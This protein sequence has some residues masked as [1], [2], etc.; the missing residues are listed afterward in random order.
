[1]NVVVQIY[2]L[3]DATFL[4]KNT[5]LDFIIIPIRNCYPPSNGLFMV[6]LGNALNQDN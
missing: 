1:M 4:I 2:G 3:V 6:A 5:T